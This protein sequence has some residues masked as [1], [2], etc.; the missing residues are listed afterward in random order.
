MEKHTK[1]LYWPESV[2]AGA[3]M[4]NFTQEGTKAPASVYGHWPEPWHRP[5]SSSLKITLMLLAH[6]LVARLRLESL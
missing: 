4:I 2:M 5:K 3:T 1:R 6:P